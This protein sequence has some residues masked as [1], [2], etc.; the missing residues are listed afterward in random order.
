MTT[1]SRLRGFS[2]CGQQRYH[3]TGGRN[4]DQHQQQQRN[5]QVYCRPIVVDKFVWE[6]AP[7][8]DKSFVLIFNT[9][10]CNHLWGMRLMEECALLSATIR[11][12]AEAAAVASAAPRGQPH[13]HNYEQAA[14]A[15]A[16]SDLTGHCYETFSVAKILYRLALENSVSFSHGVDKLSYVALYNNLSHLCKSLEGCETAGDSSSS[17][18]ALWCDEMLLKAVFWWRDSKAT[19]TT[20]TSNNNSISNSNYHQALAHHGGRLGNSSSNSNNNFTGTEARHCHNDE[21]D[22][23]IIDAFL[24]NVFYRIGVTEKIAPAAAA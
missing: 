10:L 22:E 9:A 16:L 18:E 6:T 17:E 1:T 7:S 15:A 21:D 5:H 13:H 2:Y 11:T 8:K 3:E 23:E 14:S 4:G 12:T 20:A 24:D 19:T